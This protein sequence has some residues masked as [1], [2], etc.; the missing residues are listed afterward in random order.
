MPAN[1]PREDIKKY[2]TE[3]LLSQLGTSAQS[4]QHAT[5]MVNI[6]AEVILSQ[7]ESSINKPESF[8]W[9][10]WKGVVSSFISLFLV[11]L[12]VVIYVGINTNVWSIAEQAAKAAQQQP[13]KPN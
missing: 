4:N 3:A 10:V 9:G 13:I 12:S 8:L 6:N 2:I 1:T 7:Y 5:T 11:G